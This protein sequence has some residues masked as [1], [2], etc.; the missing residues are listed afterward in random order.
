[1][2]YEYSSRPHDHLS[3]KIHKLDGSRL[4]SAISNIS[5][6]DRTSEEVEQ[7]VIRL[8]FRELV[9]IASESIVGEAPVHRDCIRKLVHL[10]V[11]QVDL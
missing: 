7:R 6:A 8:P 11:G 9:W 10:P 2:Q 3:R 5:R 4:K 1:M